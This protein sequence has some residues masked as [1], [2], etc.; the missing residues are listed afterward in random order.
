MRRSPGWKQSLWTSDAR[1]VDREGMNVNDT[2]ASIAVVRA[3]SDEGSARGAVALLR[4]AGVPGG[5]ISVRRQ[6]GLGRAPAELPVM[7]RIFWSGLW[8]SV[9]G[10]IAGALFGLLLGLLDIG[11]PGTPSNIGIQVAT[12]SMCFH[13]L[14]A[15]LGCYLVV[16]TGD[17]FAR[18]ADHHDHPLTLVRVTLR[19][20]EALARAEQV[21]GEAGGSPFAG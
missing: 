18:K 14:G 11:V 9:A 7:S 19:D 2:P 3:F 12:W 17:R 8:W 13:V 6:G 4:A 16:D 15:L 5:A 1:G 21:L 10:A 20:A